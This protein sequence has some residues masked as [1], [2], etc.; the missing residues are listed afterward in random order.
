MMD[1]KEA[2]SWRYATKRMTSQKLTPEKLGKIMEAIHLAPS[3]M[4]LQPYSVVVVSDEKIKNEITE[5]ACPQTQAKECS[6]LL[7]FAAWDRGNLE[8]EIESYMTNIAETR[9]V[10]PKDL[11]GFQSMI[12]G[13]VANLEGSTFD[14]CARQAYLGL[15]FALSAAALEGIDAGPMEGFNPQEMDRLLKLEAQGLRSVVV[16]AL[17]YRD[18]EKDVYAKARKVRRPREQFFIYH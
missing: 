15:G 1:F 14:W 6:H 5:K 13:Y 4:G 11:A 8:K 3:S 17:G 9:G 16:V 10:D 18:E 2:L 7:V 12:N